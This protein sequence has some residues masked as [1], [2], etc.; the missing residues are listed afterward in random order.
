MELGIKN[1]FALVCASSK[2]LGFS[3]VESLLEEGCN[4]LMT[5]RNLD[6]LNNAEKIINQKKFSGVLNKFE[7][8]LSKPYFRSFC[9]IFAQLQM[10]LQDC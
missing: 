8:D 2:G 10:Y 4:V 1:R 7:C 5:S 3:V 9:R 6:N